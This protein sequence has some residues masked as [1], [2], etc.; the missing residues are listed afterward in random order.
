MLILC[1]NVRGLN[2]A[3][4]VDSIRDY[5]NQHKCDIVCL[6]EHKIKQDASSI[7]RK[8][9][10][11]FDAIS[12]ISSASS[13]CILVL[14]NPLS[15]NLSKIAKIEQFIQLEG[16]SLSDSS[17]FI[18]RLCMWQMMWDR[19]GN[20]GKTSSALSR[21]SLGSSQGTST[22]SAVALRRWIGSIE[23]HGHVR[24]Q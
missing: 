22:A 2:K 10:S 7:L 24:F 15:M 23:S 12:N 16:C 1:W 6:L 14:W 18:L 4:K 20:C 5:S 9:W 3:G 21:P 13:G 19:G 8:C 11:S 17:R